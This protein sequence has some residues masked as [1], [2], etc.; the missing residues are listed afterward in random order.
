LRV[1][2]ECA[3]CILHRGYLEIEKA[4]NDSSVQFEAMSAL[5]KFLAKEFKPTAVPAHLGTERDRLIKRITGNND[6]YAKTKQ[7]SNQKALEILPL[8]EKL[9]SSESS[10][11]SRFRKACL[12]AIVGNV[13]E[14]DIPDHVFR[15]ED[16]GKLVQRAEKDLA[17][18]DISKIFKASR[19]AKKILYLADNAGEIAFDTLLVHELKRLGVQVTVAVKDKPVI[20]DATIE[21]ARYV[22]MHHVADAI[23][24][25]GTDAVGLVPEECSNEFLTIYNH[26][27]LVVAK[28]MGYAETLTEVNLKSPHA[29]LLRTKCRPV[30]NFFHV[31]TEKNVAKLM[32]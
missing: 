27:E 30:A 10:D 8:A 5:T 21:D 32:F 25:T 4:T 9:V 2:V 29:M 16:M 18:N 15:F 13:I 1:E 12:C 6:P 23:I 31:D 20:N 11:E 14:F 28:G 3:S 24:S 7:T 19:K 17:L 22:G 26:A